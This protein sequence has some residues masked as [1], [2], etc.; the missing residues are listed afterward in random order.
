MTDG[1][2]APRRDPRTVRNQRQ[3]RAA[4]PEPEAPTAQSSEAELVRRT[5]PRRP[6]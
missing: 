5:D 3:Q 4:A 2:H 1:K 6:A